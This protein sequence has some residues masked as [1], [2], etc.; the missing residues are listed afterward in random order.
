LIWGVIN[1]KAGKA[2]TFTLSQ[3][4]GADYSHPLALTC[5]KNSV[6]KS[7]LI[8]AFSKKKSYFL[9]FHVLRLLKLEINQ[10]IL[11]KKIR[12]GRLIETIE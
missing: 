10:V 9:D 8:I 3:P 7:P 11:E 5:L 1:G 4:R 12:P 6:I 2:D